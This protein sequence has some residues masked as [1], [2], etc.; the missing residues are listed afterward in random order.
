MNSTNL[1]FFSF[2]FFLFSIRN[3]AA[4]AAVAPTNKPMRATTA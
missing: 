4:D 2:N 3:V 1:F